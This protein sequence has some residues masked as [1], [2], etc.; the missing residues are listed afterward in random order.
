[1]AAQIQNG[2]SNSKWRLKFKMATQT[3]KNSNYLVETHSFWLFCNIYILLAA[4]V[5]L[6]T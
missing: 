3:V 2:G 5:I 1:M 6:E 4:A